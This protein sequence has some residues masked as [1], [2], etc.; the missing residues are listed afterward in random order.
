M[1]ALSASSLPETAAAS[2]APSRST[3]FVVVVALPLLALGAV[4]AGFVLVALSLLN[5]SALPIGWGAGLCVG[6]WALAAVGRERGLDR[7]SAPEA[8]SPSTD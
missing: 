5:V 8:A 7:T 4:V 1:R 3:P 2:E 6:G